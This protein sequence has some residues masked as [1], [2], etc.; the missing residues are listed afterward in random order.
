MSAVVEREVK[1]LAPEGFELPAM[2]GA[3]AGLSDGT[4]VHL[5]LDAVYFDSADLALARAGVTVRYRSGEAGP[6][7][8]VKLPQ[9][10]DGA[11]L[12]RME[13]RFDGDP[14]NVPT[15][16]RDLIR[17]YLRSRRL[18]RV[19]RIHTA[20]T[21][22]PLLAADGSRAAELVDDLVSTYEGR[23]QTGTFHEV[24]LEL[25]AARRSGRLQ[26]AAVKRL[27]AAGC[28]VQTAR[29]KLVRALGDRATAPA[30][31]RIPDIG[32]K[33]SIDELIRHALAASVERLIR[34]DAGVRLGEDPEDVHQFRVAA[35]TLRS[36]LKT[37]AP[38]LEAEWADV[39]RAELAWLGTETGR[40]R[41]LDVLAE[42]LAGRAAM[43]GEN[44]APGVALL[45]ERVASQ[46]ADARKALLVALRCHRYDSLLDSLVHAA[47]TPALTADASA[48]GPAR[49]F[50]RHVARTRVR[51]LERA[52]TALSRPPSDLE[53]HLLR[54]Q[55]KRTRYAIEAARPVI[56]RPAV[57]H[58]EALA[59]LQD[60]L[61]DLHDSIVAVQWLRDAAAA[62]ASCGVAAGQLIGQEL[63]EQT[64]LRSKVDDAWQA[65]D[66]ADIRA[67]L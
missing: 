61:G 14:G 42:R 2:G 16:A 28:R 59:D 13:F 17:A 63:T 46:T 19:A 43:L 51:R 5:E 26:R 12:T 25:S 67:W 30:D 23:R 4:P 20:R 34:H 48:A 15:G 60:L 64:R 29:P 66:T 38:V 11:M 24:E 58:A 10:A 39:L 53:L 55:A 8:T 41:D 49:P 56:G 18:R 6:P 33:P 1:L 31:V 35:R 36:N 32:D 52:V 21:C 37:F 3:V 40:V 54:I 45:L 27:S 47:A 44:D 57:E 62:R 22:I 7:W 65:A 9:R 50:L